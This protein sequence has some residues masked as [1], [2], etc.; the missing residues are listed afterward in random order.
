MNILKGEI[1]NIYTDTSTLMARVRIGQ[2]YTRVA[3]EFLPQ[4]KVGDHIL[5]NSGVGIAIIQALKSKE[6]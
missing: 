5:C 6:G 4:A 2:A 1:V 3:L